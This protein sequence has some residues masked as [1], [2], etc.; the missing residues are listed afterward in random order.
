MFGKQSQG[1][2]GIIAGGVDSCR[3]SKMRRLLSS[4]LIPEVSRLDTN[5]ERWGTTPDLHVVHR[6]C[7]SPRHLSMVRLTYLRDRPTSSKLNSYPHRLGF[8]HQKAVVRMDCRSCSRVTILHQVKKP[9]DLAM[10]HVSR[11]SLA[12]AGLQGSWTHSLRLSQSGNREE[13]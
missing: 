9:I 3:H 5:Q 12:T 6:S 13:S 1:K 2:M 11:E 7:V 8:E 4:Q 10:V